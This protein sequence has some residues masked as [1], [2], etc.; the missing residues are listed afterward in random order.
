MDQPPGSSVETYR[1]GTA[2]DHLAAN[3]TVVV[4]LREKADLRS[5]RSV[6]EALDAAVS[7]GARTLIVD[8]TGV[9]FVDS[10]MLSVLLRASRAMQARGDELR[11]VVDDPRVRRLFEL[12]LLDRAL[13]I[14]P[15]LEL[16][17]RDDGSPAHRQRVVGRHVSNTF[18]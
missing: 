2:R 10:M 14:F 12:T 4:A 18:P 7:A 16:A 11:L 3:A 15:T 8:L 1:A 5:A 17:R 9:T 13:R 6:R